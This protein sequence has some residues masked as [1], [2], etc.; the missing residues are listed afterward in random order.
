M[1]EDETIWPGKIDE[2]ENTLMELPFRKGLERPD[3]T[4]IDQEDFSRLNLAYKFC[5]DEVVCLGF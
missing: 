5:T 3:A 1:V 4:S 2:L